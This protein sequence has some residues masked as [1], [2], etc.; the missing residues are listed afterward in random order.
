MDH[1][2]GITI[3]HLQGDADYDIVKLACEIA[4]DIIVILVGDDTDLLVLLLH[5]FSSD[6]HQTSI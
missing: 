3:N 2:D 5:H 4:K 6:Q 1:M